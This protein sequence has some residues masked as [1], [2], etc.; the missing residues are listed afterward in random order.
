MREA[1]VLEGE[2]DIEDVLED[3][4]PREEHQEG[5]AESLLLHV[6]RTHVPVLKLALDKERLLGGKTWLAEHTLK[7]KYLVLMVHQVQHIAHLVNNDQ[8]EANDEG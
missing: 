7:P 6:V 3:E 8:V 5:Y 1:F 4:H 2:D